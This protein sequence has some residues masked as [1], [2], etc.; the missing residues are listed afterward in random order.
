MQSDSTLD[1]IV[2]FIN[3]L[4]HLSRNETIE[5]VVKYFGVKV[6]GAG[7]YSTAISHP[8]YN[9]KVIKLGFGGGSS[10]TDG[11]DYRKDGWVMFAFYAMQNP[12]PII[13]RIYAVRCQTR[14]YV[15]LL[16]RMS[17]DVRSD[18]MDYIKSHPDYRKMLDVL[19]G[20]NDL[21]S[22]NCLRTADGR[23]VMSDPYS[24]SN[25]ISWREVSKYTDKL[26]Y[27]RVEVQEERYEPRPVLADPREEARLRA[28][29]KDRMLRDKPKPHNRAQSAWVPRPLFP[30]GGSRRVRPAF[31][32][33]D[34]AGIEAKVAAQIAAL[35]RDR[36][37]RWFNRISK[38]PI[39][40]LRPSVF[41]IDSLRRDDE[42]LHMGAKRRRELEH[43]D[44][45]RV[46]MERKVREDR[47]ADRA[48][49]WK[50]HRAKLGRTSPPIRI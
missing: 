5:R 29:A 37:N 30:F 40:K 21:R 2:G 12:S 26:G 11:E 8:I 28:E 44:V 45:V 16:D 1:E 46:Q 7:H 49:K 24:Y 13:Q 34:F 19:G 14:Y 38:P 33:A 22:A 23:V 3:A 6:L 10:Y 18:D 31:L 36:T 41:I 50:E 47:A 25:N 32:P 15:A 20:T 48:R 17:S 39:P 42:G 27:I 4:G 9:D 35:E 43:G